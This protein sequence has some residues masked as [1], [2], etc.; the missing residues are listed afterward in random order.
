EACGRPTRRSAGRRSSASCS[1]VTRAAKRR[2]PGTSCTRGCAG[3]ASERASARVPSSGSQSTSRERRRPSSSS[4]GRERSG[5]TSSCESSSAGNRRRSLERARSGSTPDE[6]TL[7]LRAAALST[8][9]EAN[10][11]ASEVLKDGG[12][13]LGA[14]LSGFF[15]AAGNEPGVLFAPLTVLVAEGGGGAR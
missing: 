14:A 6:E 1:C 3:S 13:A 5:R 8:H 11:V 15:V 4:R 9:P 7:M 12:T 2:L 10:E